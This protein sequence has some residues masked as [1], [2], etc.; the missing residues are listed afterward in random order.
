MLSWT[1][2]KQ[3]IAGAKPMPVIEPIQ[4]VTVDYVGGRREVVE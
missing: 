1:K 4:R 3:R 2:M